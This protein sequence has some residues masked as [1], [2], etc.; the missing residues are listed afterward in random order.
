MIP[1]HDINLDVIC[2]EIRYNA[3]RNISPHDDEF[4]TPSFLPVTLGLSVSDARR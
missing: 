4:I 1:S 2:D 3:L